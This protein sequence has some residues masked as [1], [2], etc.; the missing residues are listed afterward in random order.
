MR[1]SKYTEYTEIYS[2]SKEFPACLFFLIQRQ[3]AQMK[4]TDFVK[5]PLKQKKEC[6]CISDVGMIFHRLEV[7]I[8]IV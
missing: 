6:R 7:T 8:Q 3:P 5:L 4:M 1:V 2:N